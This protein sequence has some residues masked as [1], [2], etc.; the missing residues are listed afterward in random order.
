MDLSDPKF[1]NIARTSSQSVRSL[2]Q[3]QCKKHQFEFCADFSFFHFTYDI[4]HVS[5]PFSQIIPPSPFPQSPKDCSIHLFL[6]CCLTNKVIVT[7]FLDFSFSVIPKYYCW[8]FGKDS[9]LLYGS[10]LCILR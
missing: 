7:I 6:F 1:K 8:H 5:V 10:L 4:I 9:P 2:W 3:H